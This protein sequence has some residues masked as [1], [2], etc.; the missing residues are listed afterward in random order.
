MQK[1]GALQ[2]CAGVVLDRR[3]MLFG[4][5][6]EEAGAGLAGL[7]GRFIAQA[8]EGGFEVALTRKGLV[9]SQ[10]FS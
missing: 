7:D 2:G 10:E 4:P 8:D 5:A 3:T 9:L 1:D 6:V